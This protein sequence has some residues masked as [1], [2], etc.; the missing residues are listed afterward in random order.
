[1][2]VYTEGDTERV[3]MPAHVVNAH[4]QR[5][6]DEGFRHIHIYTVDGTI[7][8]IDGEDLDA[9]WD[10]IKKELSWRDDQPYCAA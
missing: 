7:H 5:H 10:T 9:R 3:I 6:E 1:M 8:S 2:I 4:Y